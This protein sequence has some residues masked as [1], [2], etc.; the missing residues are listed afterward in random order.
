MPTVHQVSIDDTFARVLVGDSV[1][2]TLVDSGT[3]VTSASQ[4]IYNSAETL[5]SS[6]VATDSGSGNLYRFASVASYGFYVSE[7][8]YTVGG[9]EY[10]RRHNFK[11]VIGEV[12]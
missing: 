2:F 7:W 9:V 4:A 12:D 3:T 8:R 6:G 10:R 5:V 11:G 1:Q